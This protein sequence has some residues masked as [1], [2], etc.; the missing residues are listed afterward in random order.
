VKTL[1]KILAVFTF[2]SLTPLFIL[3]LTLKF[4][5]I[6]K[7]M[8]QDQFVQNDEYRKMSAS[9]NDYIDEQSKSAEAD[10][11]LK[12]IGPYIKENITKEYLKSKTEKLFGDTSAWLTGAANTPP[13]I[14]FNDI[15]DKI[16]SQN[17]GLVKSLKTLSDEYKKAKP[18][19]QKTM[20][21]QSNTSGD[22]VK[23]DALPEFDA[24]AILNNNLT[25]PVGTFLTW[26]KPLVWFSRTG[27]ILFLLGLICLL[28]AIYKLCG[29]IKSGIRW[30]SITFFL[31]GLFT[32]L[33]F[34]LASGSSLI[35]AQVLT[36]SHEMPPFILPLVNML[37][38]PIVLKFRNLSGLTILL[39]DILA[40][41]LFVVSFF[42]HTPSP[43]AKP[44][45]RSPKKSV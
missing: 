13:E 9:I 23:T 11:P 38:Y 15:R 8:L 41:L 19:I 7:N 22:V 5:G 21:E 34:V 16:L 37:V 40:I 35:I 43:N 36:S 1:L 18:D 45:I 31:S 39:S 10:N 26:L 33:P 17:A 6:R 25:V 27:F 29:T 12:I 20:D 2:A 14:S 24:D 42:V 4:S 28:A 44:A 3:V 30:I 32:F